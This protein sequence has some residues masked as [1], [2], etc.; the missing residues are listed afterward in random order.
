MENNT[1][2]KIETTVEVSI[3]NESL[4]S[5]EARMEAIESGGEYIPFESEATEVSSEEPATE[6]DNTDGNEGGSDDEATKVD[7]TDEAEPVKNDDA[8]EAQDE[9]SDNIKIENDN[10]NQDDKG[11]SDASTVNDNQKVETNILEKFGIADEKELENILYDLKKERIFREE[12]SEMLGMAKMLKNADITDDD[13]GLLLAIK[14]GDEGTIIDLARKANIDLD[15]EVEP[16]PVDLDKFKTTEVDKKLDDFIYEAKAKNV[17]PNRVI[18]VIE[19]WDDNS[20]IKLLDEPDSQQA[21]VKHLNNG[22]YE[23]VLDKINEIKQKDFRG[24]FS[25]LTSYEQYTYALR[26]MNN[27]VEVVETPKTVEVE[28]KKVEATTEVI[29]EVVRQEQQEANAASDS[30]YAGTD[31]STAKPKKVIDTSAMS[32]EEFEKYISDIENG[33]T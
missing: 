30:A 17:E 15:K 26:E 7:A 20:V 23:E 6:T 28:N 18:N 19:S 22:T 32:D 24:N 5:F 2:D 13:L 8:V 33:L 29:K 9:N 31:R 12:T 3:E 16:N 14:A 27:S 11:S 4:D 21:I 10:I 1:T 25:K